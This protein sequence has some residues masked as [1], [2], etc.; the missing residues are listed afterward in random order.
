MFEWTSSEEE[1]NLFYTFEQS[2]SGE[3]GEVSRIDTGTVFELVDDAFDSILV[4][5]E[6]DSLVIVEDVPLSVGFPNRLAVFDASD[7]TLFFGYDG[8][9]CEI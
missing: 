8:I 4:E 7:P 6:T 5:A 1:S 3:A 2:A 9:G